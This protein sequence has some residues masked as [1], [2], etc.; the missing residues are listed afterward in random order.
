MDVPL[1]DGLERVDGLAVGHGFVDLRAGVGEGGE[2]GTGLAAFASA[3]EGW[4]FAPSGSLFAF[5]QASLDAQQGAA[6]QA[7]L[8]MKWEF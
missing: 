2:A 6:W 4:H 3:Q 5:Q 7:G 1:R 8:G